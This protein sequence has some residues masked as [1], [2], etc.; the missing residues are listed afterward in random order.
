[1]VNEDFLPYNFT[2]SLP[3]E[4][5]ALGNPSSRTVSVL[6]S[7][8]PPVP[9]GWHEETRK[10]EERMKTAPGPWTD[11]SAPRVGPWG[12]RHQLIGLHVPARNRRNES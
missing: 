2:V 10:D 9:R 4:H 6:H 12:H 7:A 3:H 5:S 8:L 11:V 1:M